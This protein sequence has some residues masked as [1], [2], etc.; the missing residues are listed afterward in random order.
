MMMHGRGLPLAGGAGSRSPAK[1]GLHWENHL[2]QVYGKYY[3]KYYGKHYEK[4][5]G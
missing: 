4:H 1:V 5:Y 2:Y 3:G